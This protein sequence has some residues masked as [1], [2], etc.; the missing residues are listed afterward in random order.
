[1]PVIIAASRDSSLLGRWAATSPDHDPTLPLSPASL[2][3]SFRTMFDGARAGGLTIKGAIRIG[4]EEFS[5]EVSEGRLRAERGAIDDPDFCLSAAIATPI[6]ALVYRKASP[7]VLPDLE[8][9][10]DLSQLTRYVDCF[11]LPEKVR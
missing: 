11:R 9:S 4:N 1:M 7:D 6:A 5:V 10:G 3:L 8:V 2:M